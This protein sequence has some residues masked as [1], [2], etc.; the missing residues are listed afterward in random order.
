MGSNRSS[1]YSKIMGVM[2]NLNPVSSLAL[3]AAVKFGADTS[4]D[5]GDAAA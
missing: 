5:I 1:N 2:S 4:E 3:Q